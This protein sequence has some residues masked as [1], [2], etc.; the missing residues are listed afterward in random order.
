MHM[1]L[2]PDDRYKKVFPDLLLIGL[3]H[4]VRSQLPDI[5]EISRSKACGG[6]KPPCNLSKSMKDTSP[7]KS[8][9]FD[10]VYTINNDHN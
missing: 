6:K 2:A 10:D 5:E 1:I 3:D 7:F 8:I 9:H 4:L